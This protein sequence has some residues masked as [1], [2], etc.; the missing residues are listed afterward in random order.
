MFGCFQVCWSTL[1]V[2]LLFLHNTLAFT[3]MAEGD[4]FV[5]PFAGDSVTGITSGTRIRTVSWNVAAVNNN[6]FEYW[7]T[8][9]N[10]AYQILMEGVEKFILKPGE[11]DIPIYQLMT[12]AMVARIMEH[13]IEIGMKQ[14]ETVEKLWKRDYRSRK[15]VSEFLR[16]PVIGKK[17][18]ASMPD[19][20]TNTI[21]LSS[22]GMLYRPTVINCYTTE[23]KSM[24]DWFDHWMVFFFNTTVDVDGKGP[25]P[26]HSL[27][28][29]IKKAKYPD[30]TE[31]EEAASIPLQLVLQGVF[32]AILM[33]LM[34]TKGGQSWQA[35]RSEICNS[36]NSQ[37]STRIVNIIKETYRD[38]DV[39][40]LQEAG[41][42]LVDLLRFQFQETHMLIMPEKYS[43]K[44]NQNSVMLL[45][46]SLFS[47]VQEIHV[48][49]QGWDAG[50]LLAV[51]AQFSS[52]QITLASF[53]GDTNG[54]LTTPALRGLMQN[55]PTKH[56]IFGLDAN[57]Y[58][59]E[60][61]STAHVRKF[62]SEYL[63][64]GLQACWGQVDPT[65]YTTFNARTYLQPQ[66]NKAAKS[67]EL[68]EKGDRNP[69]DF[70]LLSSSFKV[71]RVWLDNTGK[72]RYIKDM[73]FPTLEFPSDHAALAVDVMFQSDVRQEL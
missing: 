61:K 19:R 26:V 11:D 7:I 30:I 13:M 28:Q 43:A 32:D 39:I 68:A 55:L 22:G 62:E 53:H 60:S 47:Q 64:L 35:L 67:T 36:L 15:V 3:R 52:Q 21:Q 2:V 4:V 71:G 59:K 63:S 56:L 34:Q 72:G 10:P 6:P 46:T 69:K 8:H 14:V 65:R 29:K 1:S 70:V 38:A 45:R 37:K 18:L 23:L 27:L 50:D 42:Q 44:R 54:L 51:Q 58:E 73:V 12:D 57:T 25:R 16:D 24:E 31:E 9:P 66:L 40:F 48:P 33:N 49:P 20:V 17:R 5:G 41:N